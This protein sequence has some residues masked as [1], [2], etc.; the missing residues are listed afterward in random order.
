[1]GF[2]G[3]YLISLHPVALLTPLPDHGEN[4]YEQVYNNDNFEENKSSFGHEMIAGGAAFAGFKAFEDHQRNEGMETFTLTTCATTDDWLRQARLP[5]FRQG[6]S[7]WLCWRR[8][9]QGRSCS[10]YEFQMTSVLT[11]DSLLR[12]RARTGLTARRPSARPRSTLSACTT[13]STL[14]TTV[15]T[16]TTPISTAALSDSSAVAGRLCTVHRT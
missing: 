4:S 11:I 16:S 8:G 9:R 14:T 6:A 10:M 13:S 12:P 3:A 1:M 2:W 15:L 5:R 7:R